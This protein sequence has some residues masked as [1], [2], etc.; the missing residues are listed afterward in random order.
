MPVKKRNQTKKEGTVNDIFGDVTFQ[1]LYKQ[2]KVQRNQYFDWNFL[3]ARMKLR[4]SD[5][6]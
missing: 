1:F 2:E 6:R 5:K 3:F 4:S